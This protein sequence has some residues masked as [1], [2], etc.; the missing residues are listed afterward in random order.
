MKTY[1]ILGA[2]LILLSLAGFLTVADDLRH[3]GE[4]AT[5]GGVGIAGVLLLVS[6]HLRYRKR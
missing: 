4:L 6:A 2:L 1:E 5:V 3:V